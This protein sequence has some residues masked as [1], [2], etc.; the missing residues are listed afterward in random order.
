MQPGVGL[1]PGPA[2]PAAAVEPLAPWA[3]APVPGPAQPVAAV[4]PQALWA[5]AQVPGPAAQVRA[6]RVAAAPRAAVA[7]ALR[8]A[9]LRAVVAPRVAVAEPN[10]KSNRRNEEFM[11]PGTSA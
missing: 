6:Q 3:A 10:Q 1:V 11:K 8:A 7:V 5:A 2:Q 9:A 4:A